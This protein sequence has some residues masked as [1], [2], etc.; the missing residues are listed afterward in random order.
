M[1]T[2]TWQ[3]AA[4]ISINPIGHAGSPSVRVGQSRRTFDP[5]AYDGSDIV[6]VTVLWEDGEEDHYSVRQDAW[7]AEMRRAAAKS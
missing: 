4:E 2:N 7:A 3:F 6:S 1:D 5:V